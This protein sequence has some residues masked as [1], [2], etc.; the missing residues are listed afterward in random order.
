MKLPPLEHQMPF[1]LR[2]SR[3]VGGLGA[4]SNSGDILVNRESVK[5]VYG[6]RLLLQP[7][8]EN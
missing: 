8:Q 6:T 5:R 1:R 7:M 2:R 4:R 3:D